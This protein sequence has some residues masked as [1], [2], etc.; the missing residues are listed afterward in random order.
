MDSQP[1]FK[2]IPRDN[3]AVE[4]Y[5]LRSMGHRMSPNLILWENFPNATFESHDSTAV[6]IS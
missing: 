3:Q 1:T 5:C 6:D 2:A 4:S